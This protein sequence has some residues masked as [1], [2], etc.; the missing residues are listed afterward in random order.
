MKSKK[1]KCILL[2]IILMLGISN[3]NSV[4]VNATQKNS[5]QSFIN[6]IK[7]PAINQYR[8]YSILPSLTIAQAMLESGNGKSGLSVKAKNLFGIKTKNNWNG[9][10]FKSLT[11]EYINGNKVSVICKFKAYNSVAESIEDHSKLLLNS[12]YYTVRKADNYKKACIEVQ[13]CGYATAPDY[14]TTLISVIES[15]NLQKYDKLAK[16]VA[17]K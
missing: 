11:V 13:K 10:V 5:S 14:A 3:I 1:N 8:K 6:S 17:K 9:K 2:I 16:Q 12:R 4:S 7:Y 15:N